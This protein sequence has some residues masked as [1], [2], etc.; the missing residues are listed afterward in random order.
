MFSGTEATPR[1]AEFMADTDA[2]GSKAMWTTAPWRPLCD[3]LGT[4]GSSQGRRLEQER[5]APGEPLFC[6]GEAPQR[7]RPSGMLRHRAGIPQ[8]LR[9]PRWLRL[10]HPGAVPGGGA[11]GRGGFAHGRLARERPSSPLGAATGAPFR[12]WV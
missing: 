8:G 7:R 3:E 12:R 6:H 10:L 2:Q 9:W 11:A 4:R 1:R 5:Q